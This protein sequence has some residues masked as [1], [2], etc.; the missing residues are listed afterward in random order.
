MSEHKNI[1]IPIEIL[2]EQLSEPALTGIVENFILR[3][4]TDYGN[5]EVTYDKKADQIRRQITRGE[6]KII[7]DQTSETVSLITVRD[8]KNLVNKLQDNSQS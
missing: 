6:I 1:E 2:P 4:G 8:Y 5:I 7:F 3:E